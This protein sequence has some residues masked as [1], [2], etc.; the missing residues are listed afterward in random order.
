MQESDTILETVLTL[1]AKYL[2][3]LGPELGHP[4]PSH[5][6]NSFQKVAA[7]CKLRQNKIMECPCPRLSFAYLSPRCSTTAEQTA[8][9][10]GLTAGSEHCEE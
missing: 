4:L 3:I 2:D 1:S 5:L 7:A 8:G 6:S 9:S 10:V